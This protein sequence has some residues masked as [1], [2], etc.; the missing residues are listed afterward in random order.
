MCIRLNTLQFQISIGKRRTDFL[1][2]KVEI[3][4]YENS[5]HVY[6]CE[7]KLSYCYTK[8][9]IPWKTYSSKYN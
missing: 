6:I 9:N 8:I 2:N 5:V 4:Y 1:K 7:N 3:V